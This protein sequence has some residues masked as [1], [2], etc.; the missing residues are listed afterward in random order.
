MVVAITQFGTD[1]FG[2]QLHGLFTCLILHGIRDYYFDG[3]NYINHNFSFEHIN[4][5]ETIVVKE[6]LIACIKQF[7]K[8]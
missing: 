8:E 7:I 3:Y 6:Y 2:H 5:D 4:N 1:G